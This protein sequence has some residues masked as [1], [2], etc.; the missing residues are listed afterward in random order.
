FFGPTASGLQDLHAAGRATL[1][2]AS[3]GA[4]SPLVKWKDG[5]PWL[6]ER[7]FGRGLAFVLTLPSSADQS[8]LALR[9]AFLVLLEKFAEAARTRNGAHRTAVGEPWS[10]EGAKSVDVVGPDRTPVR[11]V[12]EG[13]TRIAL[14]DKIGV[15]E[16]SVDGEKLTRVAGPVEREVDL[17]PR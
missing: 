11:L 2:L 1:D 15:Y 3:P 12:D 10:F 14:P 5:A 17:R 6:I 16:I 4:T 8:D 9:P 13:T 7:S